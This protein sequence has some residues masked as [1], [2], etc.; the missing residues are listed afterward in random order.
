M[1]ELG[2]IVQSYKHYQLRSHLTPIQTLISMLP[3]HRVRFYI[4]ALSKSNHN[5]QNNSQR[6]RVQRRMQIQ[7]IVLEQNTHRSLTK[8]HMYL[9]N[10]DSSHIYTHTLKYNETQFSTSWFIYYQH[11]S[12]NLTSSRDFYACTWVFNARNT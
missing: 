3:C 8:S 5:N 1:Q 12:M 11:P 6:L 4:N 9:Q 2:H 10:Q 7:S